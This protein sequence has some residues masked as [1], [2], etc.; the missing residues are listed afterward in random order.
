MIVFGYIEVV[1]RY[2]EISSI[3]SIMKKKDDNGPRLSYAEIQKKSADARAA[4]TKKALEAD[5]VKYKSTSDP[6][7][8][9][10]FLEKRLELWDSLK[11]EV[12]ENGRLK[13]GY[14]NRHHERMYNKTKEI[15]KNL[16]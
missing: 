2:K 14:T 8:F 1:L 12:I 15:L 13:K 10:T 3:Q 4:A 7:K 6:E 11:S 16:T 9:K 5:K